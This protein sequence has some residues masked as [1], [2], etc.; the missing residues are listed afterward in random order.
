MDR[1]SA[2]ETFVTAVDTGSLNKTSQHMDVSQSA[3]SQQLRKLENHFGQALLIRST[4]GVKPT[5]P[6]QTVYARAQAILREYSHMIDDLGY[7]SSHVTGTLRIGISLCL[8]NVGL[9]DALVAMKTTWPDLNLSL[10]LVSQQVDLT[11]DPL[12]LA[13]LIGEQ[14]AIGGIR[15]KLA[16]VNTALYAHVDLFG[17]TP[18]QTIEDLSPKSMV[19]CPFEMDETQLVLTKDGVRVTQDISTGISVNS[20]EMLLQAV[21]NKMGFAKLPHPLAKPHVDAGQ[22]VPLLPDY[23]VPSNPIYLLY[24]ERGAMTHTMRVVSERMQDVLRDT[25]YAKDI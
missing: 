17:A 22:L 13:L 5:G 9:S 6:G 1:M 21:M 3:V 14:S 7:Q 12:D 24:P 2:L 10:S 15:R 11:R 19:R 16:D 4:A 18:P 8:Q 20:P 25:A 23:S